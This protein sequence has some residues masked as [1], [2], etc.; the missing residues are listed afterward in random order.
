MRVA[1]GIDQLGSDADPVSRALNLSFE[2]ITHAK[3]GA[4]A[5]TRHRPRAGHVCRPRIV[6]GPPRC[7]GRLP[8]WR[9]TAPTQSRRKDRRA[10]AHAQRAAL[11]AVLP[12]AAPSKRGEFATAACA[13]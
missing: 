3:L 5:P 4:A 10:P 11:P 9:S 12:G 6:V 1:F 13:R 2:H 7:G 8:E